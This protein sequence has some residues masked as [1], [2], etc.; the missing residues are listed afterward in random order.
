VN[1]E[2]QQPSSKHFV[3]AAD[4]P[5]KLFIIYF[6]SAAGAVDSSHMTASSSADVKKV[7]HFQFWTWATLSSNFCSEC[8]TRGKA[9]KI[10]NSFQKNQK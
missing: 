6:T 2:A 9:Q 3:L 10:L 4:S 1:I 8:G 5:C 7:T